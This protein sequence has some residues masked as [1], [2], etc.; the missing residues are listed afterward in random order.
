[1]HIGSQIFELGSYVRAARTLCAALARWRAE[2]GF[3]CRLLDL[4]GG[5]GIRYTSADDPAPT[6]KRWVQ[7]LAGAVDRELARHGL[8]RPRLMVEPGR[9]IAGRAGVT[10]Y[11]VG[12]VK[13]LPSG[14]TFVTVDGGMSDNMRPALYGAR[15]EPALA[16]KIDAPPTGRV[17]VAGRHC[18][19]GDILVE[20]TPLATADAGD[21]LVVPVTGAYCYGLSSNYNGQPRPAIVAVHDG[22]AHVIVERETWSD[23][24][25]MQR[26]LCDDRQ[27]DCPAPSDQIAAV[28]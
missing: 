14:T 10:I 13:N 2:L 8:P 15:Y 27:E 21:I 1:M 12:L 3:E 9:S 18:E 5:L 25:R 11:R 17:T 26:S 28:V 23:V 20:D 24:V 7:T 6:V 22:M 4:G 16:N 19:T